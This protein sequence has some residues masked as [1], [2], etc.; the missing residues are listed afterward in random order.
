MSSIEAPNFDDNLPIYMTNRDLQQLFQ[1]L[2]IDN[3]RLSMRNEVK[4]KLLAT[5]GMR[6][7]ELV[8]LTW[9]QLDL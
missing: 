6:R 2:E 7:S 8:S 5:T 4:F 3:S 9:E 1:S